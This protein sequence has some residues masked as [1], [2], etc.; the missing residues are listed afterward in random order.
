MLNDMETFG[1]TLCY[2]N[3]DDYDF[4]NCKMFFH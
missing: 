1:S 2:Y 3:V 4:L